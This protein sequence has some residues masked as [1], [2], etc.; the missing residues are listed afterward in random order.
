MYKKRANKASLGKLFEFLVTKEIFIFEA[1]QIKIVFC[2]KLLKLIMTMHFINWSICNVIFE[3][4]GLVRVKKIIEDL[5]FWIPPPPPPRRQISN[6]PQYSMTL[7]TKYY[8]TTIP[9]T[10]QNQITPSP[11]D[12]SLA[13]LPMKFIY[14][15]SES[16]TRI[17]EAIGP[18]AASWASKRQRPSATKN[19]PNR[20]NFVNVLDFVPQAQLSTAPQEGG[21]FLEIFEIHSWLLLF[22]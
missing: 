4:F 15:L 8:Y 5:K 12:T 11:G 7:A 21:L 22:T 3:I 6:C 9:S 13:I 16:Q 14:P 1:C 17:W 10:I 2:W 20:A 18:P 19:Q